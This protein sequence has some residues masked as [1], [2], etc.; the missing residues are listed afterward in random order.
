MAASVFL[1]IGFP[2]RLTATPVN[3]DLE[4]VLG[5]KRRFESRGEML[6]PERL[7]GD[8]A[9]ASRLNCHQALRV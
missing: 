8:D 2:G 1:R 6:A 3:D 7:A 5:V 4:I 9:Q